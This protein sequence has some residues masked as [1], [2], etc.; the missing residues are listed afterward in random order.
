MCHTMSYHVSYHVN[1]HSMCHTMCDTMC[2]T[3]CE[4]M[5]HTMCDTMSYLPFQEVQFKLELG[6][7]DIVSV[8]VTGR[9]IEGATRDIVSV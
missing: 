3:M 2:H 4:T 5:C 1:S 6:K 9:H 7:G 8:R